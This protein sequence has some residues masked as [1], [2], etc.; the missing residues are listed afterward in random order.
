MK[1]KFVNESI[2]DEYIDRIDDFE[3][4]DE[5]VV[6]DSPFTPEF[7][8]EDDDDIIITDDFESV[9]N[10]ELTVPEY[11]RR[12]LSFRIKNEEGV[13]EGIPMGKTKDG[14][15]LMRIDGKYRK[16]RPEDMIEE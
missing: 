13:H 15:F 2:G 4:D 8:D 3:D 5:V 1:A 10:N 9:L 16:L 14:S 12:T 11:A 6:D 7:D